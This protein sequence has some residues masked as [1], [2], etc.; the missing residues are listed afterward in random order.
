MTDPVSGNALHI[1]SRALAE[2]DFQS[3]DLM[4]RNDSSFGQVRHWLA[5]NVS[6]GEDGRLN[7]PYKANVSPYVG[8][9]PLPNYM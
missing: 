3:Q 6:V 2:V 4:A 8:P 9:A 7:I 1:K 5:T